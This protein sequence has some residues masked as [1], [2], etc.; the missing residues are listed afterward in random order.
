[1]VNIKDKYNLTIEENIFLAKKIL[2]NSIYNSAKLEGINITFPETQTILN[3][4]NVPNVRLDDITCILNLRDAWKEVLNNINVELNLEYICKINSFI[5]RNESLEWGVLRTGQVGISG[6]NYIPN[7]PNEN[8]V[9]E[10]LNKILSI[11]NIT[12]RAI[13]YMLYGM[14]SQLFW[15]G[16][17]RTSMIIAN[18]IMIENGKGIITIKEEN[19]LEFNTLLTNYYNTNNEEEIINFIYNNCIFGIDN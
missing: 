13:K 18:K 1:M 6:T 2:V 11:E 5:S 16:N 15:D 19:L 12:L 17:K 10:N 3:G 4:V 9:K 14:R 7:I 8:D